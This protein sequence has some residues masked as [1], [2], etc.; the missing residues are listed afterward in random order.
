M[1]AQQ[2]FVIP[3]G[4][5][6]VVRANSENLGDLQRTQASAITVAR[7][8]LQNHGGG[9]LVILGEDGKIRAKD[10]IYPGNDPR[11]IRG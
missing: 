7:E 10:T 11:N 4:T 2:A 3:V 1:A 6:W 9:E 5:F 8:W